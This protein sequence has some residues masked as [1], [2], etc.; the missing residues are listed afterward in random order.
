MYVKVKTLLREA[1]EKVREMSRSSFTEEKRIEWSEIKQNMRDQIHKNIIRS[2][3]N[4]VPIIIR[5]I[6]EI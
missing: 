4:L 1:E 6:S 3:K 2:C 5:I